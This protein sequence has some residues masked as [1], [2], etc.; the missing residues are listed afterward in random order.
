MNHRFPD[1]RT[2]NLIFRRQKTGS[3]FWVHMNNSMCHNRSK[4]T[5]KIKKNHISRM[6]HPPDSS[7]INPCDFWRFDMLKQILR[8][9]EFSPRDEIED[10]IAQ[11]WNSLTF[12]NF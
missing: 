3:T 7:D 10:A 5:S 4:V 12:N 1:L 11:V 6:P 9:R 2:A 8:D